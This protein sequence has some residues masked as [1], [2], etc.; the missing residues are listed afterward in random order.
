MRVLFGALCAGGFVALSAGRDVAV[1]RFPTSPVRLLLL[2]FLPTAVPAAVWAAARSPERLRWTRGAF[3]AVAWINVVTLLNWTGYF[4]GLPLLGAVTFVAVA[5]GLMPMAMLLLEVALARRMIGA[6]DVAAAA[7]V[8]VGVFLV[9]DRS[10]GPRG[11]D[12]LKLLGFALAVVTAFTSA[13]TNLLVRQLQGYGVGAVATFGLRF[14]AQIAAAGVYGLVFS[15]VALPAHARDWVA[16]VLIG[17]L[18]IALPLYC[19]QTA[20]RTL[21]A[22]IPTLLITFYPACVLLLA[23]VWPSAGTASPLS[24]LNVA[25]LALVCSGVWLGVTTARQSESAVC[26]ERPSGGRSPE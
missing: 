20:I 17:L 25:G 21:G 18:G 10:G 12:P 5:V 15:D 26:A 7:V 23:L 24:W 6:R 13:A 4:S 19:L 9:A 16:P 11:L 8:L 14:W 22:T 1:E 3:R 2:A